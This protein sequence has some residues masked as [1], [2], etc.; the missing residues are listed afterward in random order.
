MVCDVPRQTPITFPMSNSNHPVTLPGEEKTRWAE[1]VA[2]DVFLP[3]VRIQ[4]AWSDF[5][6]ALEQGA[7]V[8]RQAHALWASWA[9]PGS[10]NRMQP[11][12]LSSVAAVVSSAMAKANAPE[13]PEW[14]RMPSVRDKCNETAVLTNTLYFMA[15]AL[16][17][18]AAGLA[19]YLVRGW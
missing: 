10:P 5:E 11:N 18:A 12:T 8:P 3:S 15:G 19:L 4:L 7:I 17:S 2:E 6:T 16:T 14:G 13:N 1:T 9:M